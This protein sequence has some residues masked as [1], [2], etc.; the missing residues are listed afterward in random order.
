M[1]P[2][3]ILHE[4]VSINADKSEEENTGVEVGMKHVSVG[5]AEHISIYPFTIGITSHQHG[6]SAQKSQV[7]DREVKEI[8]VAAIPVLQTE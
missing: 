3:R 8:N 5:F 2:E 1:F 7:R 4:Q 6:K